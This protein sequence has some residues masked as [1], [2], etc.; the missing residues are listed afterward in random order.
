MHAPA[1]PLN[2]LA[3]WL[4]VLAAF[5][6]GAA[7][8]L[9]FHRDEFLGGYGS[10]RRR[11]LRLGHIACAALGM[12]NVIFSLSPWPPALSLTGTAASIALVTG[13]VTMP[14]ACFL[15]AWRESF[16]HTFVIPVAALVL[17]VVLT[18]IGSTS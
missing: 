2:W 18:L 9:F 5:V 10:F 7:I 13:G 3:G 4:L 11:L 6:T 8:G 17:G 15:C 14:A 1:Y 12:L 16:R